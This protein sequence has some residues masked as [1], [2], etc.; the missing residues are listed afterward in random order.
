MNAIETL[1][2][3]RSI[4][5]YKNKPIEKETLDTILKAACNGST[6]GNM[7]LFS[8]IVTQ[9]KQKM[10]EMAPLHFHQPIATNAPLLLTFCADFHRFY[11]YCESRGV[12]TDAYSNLQSYHW[13][14][15]DAIIAAQNACIAA[16]SLGLG[17]CWLGT[18]TFNTPQFIDAMKLPQHVIPLACIAMGYPDEEVPLTDKLPIE[19]MVHAEEYHDYS[20]D[21]I[22]VFY[23]EKEK[24][25]N[26]LKILEENNLQNLAQVFTQKRY[27][28]EDNEHFAQVLED[29]IK[30]QGFNN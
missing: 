5:K 15:T 26:T 8:I 25:P 29:V 16:E 17:L 27:K 9:D 14:V 10:E 23:N 6:M 21:D 1:L 22:N 3:H 11:R 24:H 7:Q 20:D 28:K 13:A 18:I 4:R 30:N 19:A 12:D 2:S